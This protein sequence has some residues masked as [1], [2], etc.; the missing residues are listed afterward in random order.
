MA[1]EG[2][3]NVALM[4]FIAKAEEVEVVR[5]LEDL[6]GKPGLRQWE[7]LINIRHGSTLPQVELVLNLNIKSIP[8]ARTA[9]GP[10]EHTSLEGRGPG[11]W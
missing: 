9:S 8:G 10:P 5:I 3:F 6:R 11:A 7:A 1:D 4:G 2:I